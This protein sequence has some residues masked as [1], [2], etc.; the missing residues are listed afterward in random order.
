[1]TLQ[2]QPGPGQTPTLAEEIYRFLEGEILSGRLEGGTRLVL[3]QIAEQ[4]G[5][6]IIP[7]RDAINRLEDVGLAVS[8]PRKGAVVK[9][10]STSEL[11]DIYELRL[12]IESEATRLA[13]PRVTAEALASMEESLNDIADLIAEG[14]PG[15]ATLAEAALYRTLYEFSGNSALNGVIEQLWKQSHLYR[16]TAHLDDAEQILYEVTEH[17]VEAVKRGDPDAAADSRRQGIRRSLDRLT[18]ADRG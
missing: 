6:S 10:Y 4:V 3:R 7:V 13:T 15:D 18:A 11:I 1:M 5:T 2:R 12:L 9:S 16:I 8:E 14:R 17:T